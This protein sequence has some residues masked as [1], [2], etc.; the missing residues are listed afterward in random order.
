MTAGQFVSVADINAGLLVF[1]PAANAN[2]T[3]YASFTFQV[4]D[5]G[6]TA[7]GGVDLDQSANTLTINVTSV[8]DAP[9]N[10]V[11]G[12][13]SFVKNHALVFS[14]A[15]SNPISISDVDNTSHTVTL[16][17]TFTGGTFTITLGSTTGLTVT[18]NGTASVTLSGTDTN[19]NNAL[20]GLIWNLNNGKIGTGTLQILTSDGSL[21]DTDTVNITVTNPAGVAGA[22]IDLALHSPSIDP[23]VP[24]N[25]TIAGMPSD[26][27]SAME[28]PLQRTS[29]CPDKYQHADGHDPSDFYRRGTTLRNRNL[30]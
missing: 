27:S 6:G 24:I 3:G 10:T 8:N 14:A 29:D 20:S 25:V 4:Q 13:Q 23:T 26:W 1:T 21:T 5:D 12:A 30:D 17:G 7:N 2:G 18:G 16:S 22:P 9:V 19:I 11:P 28:Y 15:N